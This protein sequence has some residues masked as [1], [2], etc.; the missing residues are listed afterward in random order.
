MKLWSFSTTVRNPE[1]LQNF[2]RVLKVLEGEVFNQDI[3][4]EYQILLIKNRYYR[5]SH[6]PEKYQKA[7]NDPEIEISY[8]MAQEVFN[9]SDY[10]DP[11]MRGRQSVNPLNKLGFCIARESAGEI[12][13]TELGNQFLEAEQD[14]SSIFFKSLLKLQF[15]NP[16]NKDF[17]AKDGFNVSP[18]IA[19]MHLI[20]K[21]NAIEP[22]G[23][24][25]DEFCLFIPSLIDFHWIDGYVKQVFEYRKAK[26]KKDFIYNFAK[27]FYSVDYPSHKQISNFF[28]YGDNIMRY[29][30]FT[31]FFTIIRKKFGSDWRIDLEPT[32]KVEIENLLKTFDGCAIE[33][34]SDIDFFHFFYDTKQPILPWDDLTGYKKIVE[35]LL[36][37]LIEIQQ[38]HRIQLLPDETFVINKNYDNMGFEDIKSYISELRMLKVNVSERIEKETLTHNVARL[39]EIVFLLKETKS[40][41]KF[42]PE[43]FEK[44]FFDLLR[45]LNDE[46]RIIA[47]Y[48]TDDSGEPIS[49][50][51]P[52][53]PDIECYY[54]SFN[55]I[56]EVT[57]LTNNYQWIKETQPVMRHFRDFEERSDKKN[58]YCVFIAPR[59]HI[60]TA[61]HFWVSVKHGYNG[62][63]QKIIPFDTV[64]FSEFLR[65]IYLLLK[66]GIKVTHIDIVEFYDLFIKRIASVNGH[67]EW[68][69]I[70]PEVLKNWQL[71]ILSKKNGIAL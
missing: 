53:L 62:K 60:D 18:L 50:A 12:V 39:E 58:N 54:A 24:T 67:T 43:Q 10:T 35:N 52:N 56:F 1:R 30:R 34:S 14:F 15:P 57:L 28:E 8:D 7:F 21:V 33:F 4:K 37:I 40:I 69:E 3:Q 23:L 25:Q 68:L 2:L 63:Q 16:L 31:K 20:A 51:L 47:N 19:T 29:F 13:I 71:Q 5:P 38:K 41:K 42:E 61:Y 11:A 36:E 65:S 55:A 59:I 66:A 48:P 44:L 6:I 26:V 9:K 22:G 46:I 64:Q 45:I 17:S 70:I 49:H 32:R 27:N